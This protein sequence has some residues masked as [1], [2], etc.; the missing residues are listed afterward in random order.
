MK[1]A[2]SNLAVKSGYLTLSAPR[3]TMPRMAISPEVREYLSAKGRKG[4]KASWRGL[5][6]AE[7]SERARKAARKRNGNGK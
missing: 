2:L 4:G 6:K 1:A 5:S 3:P 7:R